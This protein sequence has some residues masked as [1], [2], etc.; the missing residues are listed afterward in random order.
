MSVEVSAIE[1][2]TTGNC[3]Y[4]FGV[5]TADG[6]R[7]VVRMANNET[8]DQLAGG[9]YWHA[10]LRAVGVPLAALLGAHIAPAHGFPYM[11][12]E[13]L[14]GH[15]LGDVYH[16]LSSAQRHTLA[17]EII[18]IQRRVATLLP[19]RGYGFARSY[20]DP[21]LY[22]SWLD[23]TL[24]SVERSRQRIASA[25]VAPLR[26]AERVRA[27]L[28]EIADYLRAV[29]PTPFLDDTTTKNTLIH[30]GRL[31]GIVDT[32]AVCFGDPLFTPA[33]THVALRA[34]ELDLAYA[35]DWVE[36]LQ[37]DTSQRQALSA[38]I[39]VF[40]VDFMGE[41]GQ[42]FNRDEPEPVDMRYL[43]RLETMLDEALGEA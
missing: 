32:D 38:Y 42:R 12:L 21:D 5:T 14:P 13:R 36:Q 29:P 30:E 4:V 27:S 23:V 25:G 31:S 43:R 6:Q 15:D 9:V 11:L 35:N 37:L 34:H 39:A 28:L 1:R 26:H 8:C 18:A 3:H 17:G 41:L 40:C 7:V 20:D 16:S 33:L 10:R 19:A 24:A 2:M 22:T